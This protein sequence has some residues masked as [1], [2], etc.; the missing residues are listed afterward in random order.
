MLIEEICNEFKMSFFYGVIAEKKPFLKEFISISYFFHSIYQRT[1][2]LRFFYSKF[3]LP[4][5][6]IYLTLLEI[7]VFIIFTLRTFFLYGIYK[8]NFKYFF[9]IL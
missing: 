3:V 1:F 2:I 6:Y 5:E 8:S 7:L 9:I 4:H